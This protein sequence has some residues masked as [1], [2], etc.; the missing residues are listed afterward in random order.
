LKLAVVGHYDPVPGGGA[1]G[2]MAD[3]HVVGGFRTGVDHGGR[4]ELL[5]RWGSR[6]WGTVKHDGDLDPLVAAMVEHQPADLFA[7]PFWLWKAVEK[8]V[9][10]DK[11]RHQRRP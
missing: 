7:V 3:D 2:Q 4:A 1:P 6:G 10:V 8:V 11:D 5:P 9:S